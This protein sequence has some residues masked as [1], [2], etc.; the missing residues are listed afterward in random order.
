[1]NSQAQSFCLPFLEV[2]Y[3]SSCDKSGIMPIASQKNTTISVIVE[4]SAATEAL[5]V[6]ALEANH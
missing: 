3:P 1:M 5:V 2:P 4:A 6:S